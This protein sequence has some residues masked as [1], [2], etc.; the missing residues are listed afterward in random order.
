MVMFEDDY[1]PENEIHKTITE[2]VEKRCHGCGQLR[3]MSRRA[4]YC[5]TCNFHQ[6]QGMD[7]AFHDD[8][9]KDC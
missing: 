2:I 4:N 8:D 6:E 5:L 9:F 3:P 1:D 7:L